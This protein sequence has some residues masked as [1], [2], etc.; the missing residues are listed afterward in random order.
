M[1]VAVD[2]AR[3]HVEAGRIELD[4]AGEVA[5][6]GGDPLARDSDVRHDRLFRRHDEAAP[7]DEVVGQGALL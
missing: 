5:A 2:R 1:D 7:D 6:D 4:G 3:E